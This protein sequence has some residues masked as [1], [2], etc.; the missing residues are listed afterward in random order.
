[1]SPPR[2]GRPGDDLDLL[3]RLRRRRLRRRRKPVGLL[4]AGTILLLSLVGAGM[5]AAVFAFG[6]ACDLGDLKPVAIGQNTFV[7][8]AD[9]SL[10]R[11][12]VV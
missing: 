8:A 12:S 4:I 11:K 7:Y 6:P 9:G 5:G 2:R 1:M 3:L 10:D